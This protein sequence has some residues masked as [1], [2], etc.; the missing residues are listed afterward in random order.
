M[1]LGDLKEAEYMARRALGLLLTRPRADRSPP[2]IEVSF[3]PRSGSSRGSLGRPRFRLVL[4]LLNTW[5]AMRGLVQGL[6][7]FLEDRTPW[8][9][10]EPGQEENAI[11]S[12][13]GIDWKATFDNFAAGKSEAVHRLD[14]SV[15]DELNDRWIAAV[16]LEVTLHQQSLARAFESVR[17]VCAEP[18]VAMLDDLEV[19]VGALRSALAGERLRPYH[20][21]PTFETRL[22]AW[23][24]EELEAGPEPLFQSYRPRAE[25]W[26]GSRPRRLSIDVFSRKLETWR[27]Q[28]LLGQ[29][30]LADLT[31]L[32][33]SVGSLSGLYELWCFTELIE[34]ARRLRRFEVY[35]QSFLLRGT[36]SADFDL[37]DGLYAYYDFDSN[38]FRSV[39]SEEVGLHPSPALPGARVEW[40][41][42]NAR[43]FRR[44][45]VLDTKY[46]AKWDS[47]EALK[48]LGYMLSFGIRYGAV[49]F[50]G[51]LDALARRTPPV[52]EG[53]FRLPCPPDGDSKLW[54]L[55]LIP[56]ADAEAAN[57]AILHDF[58]RE[59][60][61]DSR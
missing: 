29:V 26:V 48:V 23:F 36:E 58:L 42:R 32:D 30:W 28:Y 4:H 11:V 7:P 33:L 47:G 50:A 8:V 59:A 46:Y 18:L 34:C 38:T 52:R 10:A 44:S 19:W 39:R 24:A 56:R 45:I 54:V 53:L 37:G 3:E 49:L 21:S 35:Q 17:A 55:R 2:Q 31:G 27:E 51:E 41:L 15:P 5:L 1:A 9:E 61:P 6:L 13:R 22:A 12:E 43:D 40:I 14:K 57:Q 20:P 16:L 25:A 60:L